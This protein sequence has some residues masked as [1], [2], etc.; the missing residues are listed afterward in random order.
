MDGVTEGRFIFGRD[1]EVRLGDELHIKRAIGLGGG[2][3]MGNFLTLALRHGAPPIVPTPPNGITH[4]T[5]DAPFD[6]SIV[7]G[8]ASVAGS[9]A[10]ES[11]FAAEFAGCLRGFNFHLEFRPFVFLHVD[12]GI[13]AWAGGDL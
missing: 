12:G 4:F 9:F 8:R 3:A 13:A 11:D 10:N 1:A 2:G 5:D 6:F 7:D